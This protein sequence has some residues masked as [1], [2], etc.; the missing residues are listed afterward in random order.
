MRKIPAFLFCA[1]FF[2]ACNFNFMYLVPTKIPATT[3]EWRMVN[4]RAG[5]TLVIRFG[6][7]FQPAFTTPKGEEKSMSYTA[8]SVLIPNKQNK[9]I[10]AWLLKPKANDNGIVLYVLHGNGGNILMQYPLFIPFIKKGF[11]VFIPDY[12]GYGFSEGRATRANVLTDALSAFD[13]MRKRE[14]LNGKKRVIYGQSL[15]GHLSAVVAQKTETDIDA[16]VVEGAFSSHKDVAASRAGFIGRWFVKERYSAVK[17]IQD[18]HKP[19]LIIHSAEDEVIPFRMGQKIYEN[20]NS[21]KEFYPVGKCHVCAPLYYTD[22]IEQ[23]IIRM[24]K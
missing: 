12:S 10:H 5:D 21:P 15:G 19:V 16:L 8:E 23:K 1:I 20:A 24:V 2:S 11:T 13:Y 3:K 18:F 9:K 14:D 4:S 17:S 7:N 22:S 6:E